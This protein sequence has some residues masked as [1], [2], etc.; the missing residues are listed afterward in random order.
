MVPH[1]QVVLAIVRDFCLENPSLR[2][3]AEG[4]TV[5]VK[6]CTFD[7]ALRRRYARRA[8]HRLGPARH[9]SNVSSIRRGLGYIL[10]HI[11]RQRATRLNRRQV[12]RCSRSAVEGGCQVQKQR[13]TLRT[14]ERAKRRRVHVEHARRAHAPHQV[15]AARSFENSGEKGVAD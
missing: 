7:G 10:Q 5:K 14:C 2:L 8:H 11:A 13:A 15:E 4:L 3:K 1:C 6:P 12:R 9:H